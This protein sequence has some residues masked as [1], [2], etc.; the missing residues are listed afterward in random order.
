[1]GWQEQTC[2]VNPANS[3]GI[4]ENTNCWPPVTNGVTQAQPYAVLGWGFYSPAYSCPVGYSTACSAYGGQDGGF[5]FQFEL[6]AGETA[7]GCCP[8]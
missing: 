3:Q 4:G 2:G 5:D 1:M 7:V 6:L 8:T